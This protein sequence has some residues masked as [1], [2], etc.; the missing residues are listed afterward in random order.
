MSLVEAR[1]LT[2][3]GIARAAAGISPVFT[4]TPLVRHDD[5]DAWLGARVECKVES[6][7]PLRSFKGRGGDW[8]MR[9]R[10]SKDAVCAAS[11]GNFGQA[12]AYAAREAGAHCTMFASVHANPLKVARMRALGANVIQQGDDFDGAK[13]AARAYAH[14]HGIEFV[15]DGKAL[16]ITEGAGSIGVEIAAATT[17]DTLL[18][19]L[20]NGALLAGVATWMKHASPATRIVGVVAAGAPSM[21]RALTGI[22][23]DHTVPVHTIADGIAVRVPVDEAVDD[24]RG[25]FDDLVAVEEDAIT[26]AMRGVLSHLGLAI[27]PAGAVG[28]AALLS[29]PHGSYGDRVG[30]ILCGG[31]ITL[32]QM[33]AWGVVAL[34]VG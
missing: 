21:L 32:A 22:Q 29:A 27:E 34:P 18:V 17:L 24:L 20:G 26:A 25:L 5:L 6:L 9:Q 2:P 23:V 16:A 33:H 7:G 12:L 8:F 1:R 13:D 19:P 31:N 10:A 3:D 15:E 11:A 30:T 4:H 28:I 14:E